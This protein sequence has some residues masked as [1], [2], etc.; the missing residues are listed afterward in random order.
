MFSANFSLSKYFSVSWLAKNAVNGDRRLNYQFR[1]TVVFIAD[2]PS[3]FKSLSGHYSQ[4]VFPEGSPDS[5]SK[6][7]VDGNF[8][9]SDGGCLLR[10]YNLSSGEWLVDLFNLSSK[11]LHHWPRNFSSVK[12]SRAEFGG[13]G[14]LVV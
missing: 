12:V 7:K 3:H 4:Y 14:L 11:K 10:S 5:Y 2:L 1:K 13:G 8:S 6:L 9:S